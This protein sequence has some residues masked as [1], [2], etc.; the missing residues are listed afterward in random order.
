M[1]GDTG[2]SIN[3]G[4]INQ[5]DFNVCEVSDDRY[6]NDIDPDMN[7]FNESELNYSY[8][9][10]YTIDEFKARTFNPQ[11]NL[12][13]MHHNCRSIMSKDKLDH[14]EL[15]LDMLGDPF[16]IIGLTETWL[17][18]NN[19]NSPIF[20]DYNYNHVYETRPLESNSECKNE[21]GGVSLFIRDHIAFKNNKCS[22]SI[23]PLFR[24]AFCRN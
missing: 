5:Y 19:V 12:N 6:L 18:V 17:N 3:P 9:K 15:F 8:F 4:P 22:F 1:C 2:S 20:K 11:L 21:W 16:D 24:N 10:S 7:Y 23:Y 13:I 14:Y